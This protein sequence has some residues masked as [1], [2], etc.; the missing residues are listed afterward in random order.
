M[1]DRVPGDPIR[2]LELRSVR[3]TGGGP[4]KT[5]L[6]G[7]AQADRSRYEITVCYIRD[8]RDTVFGIDQLP[9]A[10]KV[11]Y[12]EILER[13]SL[14]RR[15]W[16]ALRALVRDRRIDIVHA[17]EYKTDILAL[18]L[19]RS[20]PVIPLATAHGWTGH[21]ARE[22]YL[23]YPVDRRALARFPAVVA[24]SEQIRGEIIAAGGAP[25]RI[26][27]IL[28][29]IDHL[30]FK[31][32]PSREAAAR[33]A[34]DFVDGDVVIGGVGRLEPQKRFDVLI[35]ACAMLQRRRPD[36][37]LV[38]AGDGSLRASL[39]VQASREL[40][41]GSWRMPGHVQDVRAVHHALDLFVQSSDYEGTPNAVLEAM[42]LDTPLVATVA[43]GTDE[44]VTDEVHGLLLKPGDVDALAQR[45]E[46]AL[47][48]PPAARAR[49]RAARQR[50]EDE[51]SFE[52]RMRKLE[53][54]YDSLVS[55][56]RVNGKALPHGG[57][58]S[59]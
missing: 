27:T 34:Y 16:P 49:A 18:L 45:I 38:I 36:L 6:S 51:L 21:S 22:R 14:D 40:L 52:R 44:L 58:H 17:H 30:A 48:D 24:V 57:G 43:G 12:V 56:R 19:G 35:S 13:H 54:I 1:S 46:K 10:A 29:G 59:A 42:A 11:D 31:R 47:S 41:P 55:Q 32:D 15:I 39:E 25:D 28:N 5:I 50:I 4:E 20:E 7:A 37:R 23:Y 53:S 2:V 9:V 33:H 26:V 8:E 3:G